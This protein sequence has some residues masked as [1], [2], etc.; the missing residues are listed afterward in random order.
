LRGLK[1]GFDHGIR[2]L[3][4]LHELGIKD[5]G[6]GITLSDGNVKDV[7]ELYNL[8]EWLGVEFATAAVH[9]LYYFHKFD[10]VIEDREMMKEELKKLIERQMRS[11]N[12]KA[13]FRGYFNYGLMN[14]IDGN[15]RLL[16]CAMGSD[17][18]FLDPFGEIRPCNGME[19]SM[20]NIKH[21]TFQEI[22]NSPEAGKIRERVKCCNKNC[23]MV[24]S[25]APAIKKEIFKTTIWI[26]KYKLGWWRP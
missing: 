18:F 20:G 22:W 21:G 26:F 9:N 4:K 16:P 14:Y 1:D 2:T 25:A 11:K 8:A 3:I 10:N 12:P 24:G 13:W 15:Q 6:F 5:I 7:M 17:V 23:W 19:A